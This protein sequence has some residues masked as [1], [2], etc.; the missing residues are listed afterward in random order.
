MKLF[1]ILFIS[2][3]AIFSGCKSEKLTS[4][5]R[6]SENS[7]IKTRIESFLVSYSK[8]DLSAILPMLSAS[9]DFHFLGSDVSEIN[10]SKS[11]FQNQLINDWKLFDSVH[12]G[13]INN[14]SMRI[15]D[16]GDLAVTVFDAPMTVIVRGNQSKIFFRM[17]MTFIKENGLWQMVQGLASVPSIGESSIEL[18]QKL[19]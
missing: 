6:K 8:K 13:E 5:Q 9:N 19:K 11:D 10:R 16:C 4:H 18:I 7:K 14:L 15:S 17:S 12:F 1:V 3:V 2:A